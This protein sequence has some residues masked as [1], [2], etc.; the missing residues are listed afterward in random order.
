MVRT[1]T[2][3]LTSEERLIEKLNDSFARTIRESFD[4]VGDTN[5]SYFGIASD[6]SILEDKPNNLYA[7]GILIGDGFNLRKKVE[8]VG[9]F[10]A[11]IQYIYSDA[12]GKIYTFGDNFGDAYVE[13][14]SGEKIGLL[15]FSKHPEAEEY[16]EGVMSKF[17]KEKTDG[18][19]QRL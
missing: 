15:D 1:Y 8:N 9:Y 16:I 7:D 10:D 18:M 4:G 11:N 6:G 14:A 5:Y 12:I 19:I 3:T 13:L 2:K 17:T